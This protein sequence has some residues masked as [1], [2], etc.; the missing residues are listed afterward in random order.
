VLQFIFVLGWMEH[1]RVEPVDE[2]E[3]WMENDRARSAR[4]GVRR[5]PPCEGGNG[6]ASLLE[7]LYSLARSS[8]GMCI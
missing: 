2:S 1:G 3:A 7:R 8:P 5:G 6:L 4:N